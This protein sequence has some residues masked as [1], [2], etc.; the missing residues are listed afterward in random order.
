MTNTYLTGNAL[1]STSPK[2]LS[3]NAS[4][5]D[6]AINSPSPSFIDRF[7]KRRQTWAGMEM[8]FKTEQEAREAD[9]QAWLTASGYEYLGEY[10]AG[11][12]FTRRNQYMVRA[13]IAYRL[14]DTTSIPYTTT[15]NWATEVSLFAAFSAD[16]ALRQDLILPSGSTLV[17]YKVRTVNARL[18]DDV[19]LLDYGTGATAF[20]NSAATG[21]IVRAPG[22]AYDLG[23]SNL[24]LQGSRFVFDGP[25]TFP[26]GKLLGAVI[27][28]TEASSNSRLFGGGTGDVDFTSASHYK[29]GRTIGARAATGLQIGGGEPSEGTDGTAMYLDTYAGWAV[30]QNTK[31]PGPQELA[32]QPKPAAHS[33]NIVA[34]QNIVTAV[35]PLFSPGFV[36]KRIYLADLIYVID[37]YLSP[38]QVRVINFGGVPAAFPYTGQVTCIVCYAGGTGVCN[39]VGNSV[40]R[41]SGDP[42]VPMTNTEYRI[43][44]NGGATYNVTAFNSADSVTIADTLGALTN[45][46][47]E[48]WTSVDNLTARIAI[49]RVSAA[50]FEEALSL[51]AHANGYFRVQAL[52]SAGTF[53]FRQ[54]PLFLGSGYDNTGAQRAHLTLD[55]NN[56]DTLVGGGF[57]K[58]SLRVT[59]MD[60]L[61]SNFLQIT[62]GVAGAPVLLA[63][64]GVDSV[65]DLKIMTKGGGLVWLGPSVA[66]TVTPDNVIFV[67]NRLGQTF[68]IPCRLVP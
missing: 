36:G 64:D 15:G 2:D 40:S 31:Y 5:I 34:G 11:L 57:G 4:N 32:V 38:T 47:Y 41:V 14:L 13:G 35:V 26:N 19:H 58:F 25:V 45:A 21:R 66:G 55:G 17:G 54:Y 68:Q 23:G 10:A 9:Y 48:W 53:P 44:I 67:K 56:G 52:A 28:Q 39:I 65:V 49:H 59:H 27:E 6:E 46:T 63:T 16:S 20:V 43:K 60:G 42:F 51:S 33:A 62:G 12:V 61:S 24:L 29:F 1:G 37:A 30:M 18:N 7:L 22:G 3:D 8:S 50:G